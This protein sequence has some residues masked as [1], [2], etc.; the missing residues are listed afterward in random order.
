[1]ATVNI[2]SSDPESRLDRSILSLERSLEHLRENIGHTRAK[3][4]RQIERMKDLMHRPEEWKNRAEFEIQ[5]RPMF[6][7]GSACLCGLALGL[8]F[9]RR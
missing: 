7:M 2:T 8:I 3:I 6:Y 9:G 4:D 1:M 5:M